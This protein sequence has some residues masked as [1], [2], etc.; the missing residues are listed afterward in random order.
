[1]LFTFHERERN[2][3][4]QDEFRK[5]KQ[6]FEMIPSDSNASRHNETQEKLETF[7]EE[8]TKGVIIWARARWHEH[9]EKSTTYFF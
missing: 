1:M 4:I 5:A 8:K 7:Y 6:E 3:T 9:G 2:T